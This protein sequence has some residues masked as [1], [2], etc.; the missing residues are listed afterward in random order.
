[1]V[2][3][4]GSYPVRRQPADRW[5]D[6]AVRRP[7]ADGKVLLFPAH[8]ALRRGDIWAFPFHRG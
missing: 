7:H 2:W 5:P 8:Q 6:R 3:P 1:M 4:D